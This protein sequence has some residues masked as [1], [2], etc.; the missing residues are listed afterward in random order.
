MCIQLLF[1]FPEFARQFTH[2]CYISSRVERLISQATT[3]KIEILKAPDS[4][5]DDG[6]EEDETSDELVEL[7]LSDEEPEEDHIIESTQ[8]TAV[9]LPETSST[10]TT[11]PGLLEC[12]ANNRR[13]ILGD[14]E[15][16][17]DDHGIAAQLTSSGSEV[18]AFIESTEVLVSPPSNSDMESDQPLQTEETVVEIATEINSGEGGNH[19][20][21]S[22]SSRKSLILPGLKCAPAHQAW[23][24]RCSTED[25]ES[26]SA[27]PEELDLSQ[28]LREELCH[29]DSRDAFGDDFTPSAMSLDVQRQLTQSPRFYTHLNRGIYGSISHYSTQNSQ[30]E[31]P[32]LPRSSSKPRVKPERRN[33][34]S[35]APSTI[36][37]DK[38]NEPTGSE[39]SNRSP[40][41]ILENCQN[42]RPTSSQLQ[43]VSVEDDRIMNDDS[44]LDAR[45]MLR[46][47]RASA[48]AKRVADQTHSHSTRRARELTDAPSGASVKVVDSTEFEGSTTLGFRTKSGSPDKAPKFLSQDDIP[49]NEAINPEPLPRSISNSDAI[50][51]KSR[52]ALSP[53]IVAQQ[54]RI[55]WEERPPM[56]I[57]SALNRSP[58]LSQR[59]LSQGSG[60]PSSSQICVGNQ[61]RLLSTSPTPIWTTR[62]LLSHHQ[63]VMEKRKAESISGESHSYSDLASSPSRKT[64]IAPAIRKAYDAGREMEIVRARIAAAEQRRPELEEKHKAALR[65][66]QEKDKVI[67]IYSY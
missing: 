28:N 43:S 37:I 1:L 51:L 64:S 32:T 16:V 31:H 36:S 2:R 40:K 65:V 47:A 12:M 17:E 53:R 29:E 56:P 4:Q 25:A 34:D 33:S 20:L 60:T 58:I 59:S 9:K 42:S 63:P 55:H 50:L 39:N 62:G 61:N 44:P 48:I 49:P 23:L 22:H 3:C 19:L 24:E 26:R 7:F 5:S 67:D 6:L 14:V 35:F 66:K 8:Q 38:A 21:L 11:V 10:Q 27:S 57:V 54:V 18:K 45:E 13:E 41:L 46:Q 52:S 15:N 30:D